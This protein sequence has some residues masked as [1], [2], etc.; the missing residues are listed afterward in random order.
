MTRINIVPVEELSDQH[1]LA[2]YH[3][4]PRVIKQWCYT[5][6]APRKYVLGKGHVKWAR[7]H[8]HYTIDRYWELCKEMAYRGFKVNYTGQQLVEYAF[9]H[10][11]GWY[12]YLDYMPTEEDIKLNQER[13]IEKYQLKPNWYRWTK[14]S[15][16]KYYDNQCQ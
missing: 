6:L 1:L 15:K 12:W 10:V 13:L 4:L 8:M 2:E 3:E 7:K 16:P 14:R 11:P 9:S 5:G